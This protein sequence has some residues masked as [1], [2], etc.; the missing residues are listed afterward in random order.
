MS[1]LSI[2]NKALIVNG[3]VVHLAICVLHCNKC[4]DVNVLSGFI[5]KV[6]VELSH[7]LYS[8]FEFRTPCEISLN[9]FNLNF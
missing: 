2:T 5:I 7:I 8:I 3:N 1:I 6:T 4:P 9:I